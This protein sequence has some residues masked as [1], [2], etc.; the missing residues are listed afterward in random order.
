M[1]LN[2]LYVV[3]ILSV[4]AVTGFLISVF[5]QLSL[6]IAQFRCMMFPELQ[7]IL[8]EAASITEDVDQKLDETDDAVRAVAVLTK[9]FS[10]TLTLFNQVI[11]TPLVV[12]GAVAGA[13]LKAA[14][15]LLRKKS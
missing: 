5:W 9:S 8:S 6:A 7:K 10:K 2:A 13:G 11:L 1:L 3:L 14:V 4:M 15:R 12:N